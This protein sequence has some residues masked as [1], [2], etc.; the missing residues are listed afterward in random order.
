MSTQSLRWW[1]SRF[2]T[3]A[4]FNGF[5]PTAAWAFPE[6]VRHGYNNCVTCHVSPS[7]GG[8]LSEY[9]REL[10]REVLSTWGEEGESRFAYGLFQ[11]PEWL[12]LGGDVRSLT[13]RSE[14][15]SGANIQNTFLMQADLEAAITMREKLSVVGTFGKLD[16]ELF[17]GQDLWISRRHY[18]LLRPADEIS[19]RAGKF[20]KNYG[21][22]TA[23]HA[24]SIK[25]GLAM[26]Q[27]TETYNLE[28]GWLGE[29]Y[30]FSA[31]GVLGRPDDEEL[32]REKGFTASGNMFFSEKMRVGGSYLYGTNDLANRHLI[33]PWATL[34]FTEH[35][36]WLAELDVQRNFGA[37]FTDAQWGFVDYQKLGFEVVKGLH[38]FGTQEFS[39][40]N[41]KDPTGRT[42]T[43][44]LGLQFF[45]RPHFEFTGSWETRQN[46]AASEEFRDRLWLMVHY[47]F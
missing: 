43:F 31:T 37:S 15:S 32:Q 44:G 6:L 47:Y 29:K 2:F 23:E 20:S 27:G 30:S 17:E 9:G 1:C 25:Q 8:L 42:M 41:F 12:N 24:I 4:L 16:S 33:G 13:L 3:L 28:L 40:L 46:L 7:G 39:K 21:I 10:S 38:F 5:I 19:V 45:P 26:D 22:N 18:L 11:P 36:Y 14:S 34:A 35:L